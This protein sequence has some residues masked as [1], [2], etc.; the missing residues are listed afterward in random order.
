MRN[1]MGLRSDFEQRKSKG[2]EELQKET[3]GGEYTISTYGQIRK[4]GRSECET[5]RNAE[6]IT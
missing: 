6:R 4:N 5:G 1:S 2:R 3:E